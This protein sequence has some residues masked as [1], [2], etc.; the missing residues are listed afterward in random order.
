MDILTDNRISLKAK[1]VYT[2][3]KSL[4]NSECFSVELLLNTSTDGRSSILSAI[5]ELKEFGYCNTEQLRHEGKIV[6][7]KYTFK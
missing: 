1:G 4:P 7:I 2:I 5:K 3:A 6:K